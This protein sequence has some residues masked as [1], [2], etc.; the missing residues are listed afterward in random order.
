MPQKTVFYVIERYNTGLKWKVSLNLVYVI[1]SDTRVNFR[2]FDIEFDGFLPHLLFF[3]VAVWEV[4][5][6]LAC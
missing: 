1:I 5:S 2:R 4:Y 3:M 6:L